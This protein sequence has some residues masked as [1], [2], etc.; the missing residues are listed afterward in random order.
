MNHWRLVTISSGRSPFSKNL[1]LC[2][3]GRGSPMRSPALAQQFDDARARLRQPKDRP[4]V[5]VLL[6]GGGVRRRPAVAAPRHGP[7]RAVRLDDRAHRQRQLAPPDH[8]GQVAER[9]DHRDAGALFRDRPADAGERA[10]A[11]RSSGVSTSLAEQRLVARVVGMRDERHARRNQLRARRVDLDRAAA[12]RVREPQCGDT[13]RA[14][15][16]PRVRPARPR[17]GNRR[18]RAS[19]LRAGRPARAARACRNASC[20]TRRASGPIVA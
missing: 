4:A 12:R 3:I 15:R 7:Q 19:A 18:P 1:T 16:D 8:V 11:R 14:S 10:P 5:V 20:D 9:A 17:C 6:R 2:V 13:R